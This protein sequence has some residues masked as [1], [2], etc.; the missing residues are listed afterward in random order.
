M[1]SF[2]TVNV[3]C[4]LFLVQGKWTGSSSWNTLADPLN[5]DSF[6]RVAEIDESGVQVRNLNAHVS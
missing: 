6:I 2:H 1:L 3:G 4:H 5:G